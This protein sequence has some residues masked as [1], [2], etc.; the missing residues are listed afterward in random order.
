MEQLL[1][2]LLYRKCCHLNISC[3]ICEGGKV[4]ELLITCGPCDAESFAVI[5][6]TSDFFYVWFLQT[7]IFASMSRKDCVPLTHLF[8][9]LS[10]FTN[11]LCGDSSPS[12]SKFF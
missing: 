2:I 1:K 9:L 11:V 12:Q 4:S 5:Q 6:A 7:E 3:S 10:L 8:P